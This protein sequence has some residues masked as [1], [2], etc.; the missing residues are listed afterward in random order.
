MFCCDSLTIIEISKITGWWVGGVRSSLGETS[1][2]WHPN[3]N[4]TEK[5]PP[6]LGL[7]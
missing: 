6:Y 3:Q 4:S 2:A 1:S 7:K 5:P